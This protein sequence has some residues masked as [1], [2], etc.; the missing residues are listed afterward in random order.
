MRIYDALSEELTSEFNWRLREI[1]QLRSALNDVD[2]RDRESVARAAFVLLYAHWEGFV[3]RALE[4]YAAYLIRLNRRVEA[5]PSGASVLLLRNELNHLF[6]SSKRS[7]KQLSV[8]IDRITGSGKR[9][10]SK[11]NVKNLVDVANMYFSSFEDIC[12][13]CGVDAT[14]FDDQREFI[15]KILLRR[16]H[17]IAHGSSLKVGREDFEAASDRVIELARRFRNR[18]ESVFIAASEGAQVGT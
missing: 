18:L 10:L 9:K 13:I 2:D 11:N 15:D 4:I 7:N 12:V 14:E 6:G 16:R 3:K 8:I 1:H 5:L 17:Q